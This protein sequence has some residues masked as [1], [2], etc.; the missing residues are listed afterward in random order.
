MAKIEINESEYKKLLRQAR[1]LEALEAGGVDNWD[2]YD[3]SLKG[4]RKEDALEELIEDSYELLNECLAEAEVDEPAGRGCGYSVTLDEK[5]FLLVFN[6][7][8][9]GLKEIEGET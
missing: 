5:S 7:I 8:K 9:D 1:K 2:W 6:K 4:V 3:E